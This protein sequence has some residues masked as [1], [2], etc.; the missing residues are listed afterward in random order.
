MKSGG[1]LSR[2]LVHETSALL[3][4]HV[5]LLVPEGELAKAGVRP[6]RKLW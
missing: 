3:I 1:C 2:V 6:C 4:D 5:A